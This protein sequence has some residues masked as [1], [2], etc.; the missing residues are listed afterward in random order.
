MNTTVK[1]CLFLMPIFLLGIACGERNQPAAEKAV[2]REPAETVGVNPKAAAVE[3]KPQINGYLGANWGM[4]STE[5]KKSIPAMV[6]RDCPGTNIGEVMCFK[7]EDGANVSFSFTEG[8]LNLVIVGNLESNSTTIARF[9]KEFGAPVEDKYKDDVKEGQTVSRR[10][11]WEDS[12]GTLRLS[13][14]CI[15]LEKTVQLYQAHY[16]SKDSTGRKP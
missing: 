2:V 15:Q 10:L 14:D 3:A 6:V 8:K 4:S 9:R 7:A 11:M 13:V 1:Q 16:M 5:V 12:Y